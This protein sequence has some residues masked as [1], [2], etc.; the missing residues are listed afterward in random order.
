MALEKPHTNIES[1]IP[2][3]VQK[4][5]TDLQNEIES[6]KNTDTSTKAVFDILDGLAAQHP[7]DLEFKQNYEDIKAYIRYR[8]FEKAENAKIVLAQAQTRQA[9]LSSDYSSHTKTA[10]SGE[11]KTWGTYNIPMSDRTDMSRDVAGRPTANYGKTISGDSGGQS[12]DKDSVERGRQLLS[13]IP[14]GSM[15][16]VKQ[17]SETLQSPTWGVITVP[18]FENQLYRDM[19]EKHDYDPYVIGVLLQSQFDPKRLSVHVTSTTSIILYDRDGKPTG[20]IMPVNKDVWTELINE[21]KQFDHGYWGIPTNDRKHYVLLAKGSDLEN[22]VIHQKNVWNQQP[23]A[24]N[25]NADN[26]SESNEKDKKD[27]SV[28]EIE[29]TLKEINPETLDKAIGVSEKYINL[30]SDE[31]T[32]STLRGI[33]GA[34]ILNMLRGAGHN[35]IIKDGRVTIEPKPG[36]SVVELQTKLQTLVDTGRLS[37]DTLKIGLLYGSPIF[38]KYATELGVTKDA[39]GNV[40]AISPQANGKAFLEHV[41]E[42]RKKWN[43]PDISSLLASANMLESVNFPQA[44]KG[45]QDLGQLEPFYKKNPEILAAIAAGANTGGAST[46]N[47]PSAWWN[48]NNTTLSWK[49]VWEMNARDINWAPVSNFVSDWFKG[50]WKWFNDLVSLGKW[51]PIATLA[52]GGAL[53]YGI[54]RMFNVGGEFGFF[55]GIGMIFWLGV[56][57]NLGGKVSWDDVEKTAQSVKNTAWELYDAAKNKVTGTNDSTTTAPAES[58]D[59]PSAITEDQKYLRDEL[60]KNTSVIASVDRVSKN[61][62]KKKEPQTGKIDDYIKFIETDLKD[63]PLNK[64]F[65]EEHKESIFWDTHPTLF[66]P[67]SNL[68]AKI[69]KEVIRAYLGGPDMDQLFGTWNT[70]GVSEKENFLKTYGITADDIKNK[71]LSHILTQIHQKRS[72]GAQS[73]PT[74]PTSWS[75]QSSTSQPESPPANSTPTVTP[76]AAPANFVVD[77]KNI[78]SG[79]QLKMKLKAQVFDEQGNSSQLARLPKDGQGKAYLDQDR[80]VIVTGKLITAN[81][82]TLAEA[83]YAWQQIY[84]SPQHLKGMTS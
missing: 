35:L 76:S 53:I 56:L 78:V 52:I 57:N 6:S 16:T 11:E 84:I 48:T 28:K 75:N 61:A 21:P 2:L 8:S 64:L 70:R 42:L 41:A 65:P 32:K 68:N 25:I 80:V 3:D 83:T 49:I 72:A 59:K 79:D 50:F 19:I 46:P 54:W 45:F 10:S 60:L 23:N 33:H 30:V 71:N 81:G 47:T 31:Q 82:I 26:T 62:E 15:D 4:R 1:I 63:T 77:G 24:G 27:A 36:V 14:S 40:I 51:D 12:F 74:Q 7:A 5:L 18:K 55:K 58:T 9:Q 67:P 29:Q 17:N 66:S 13:R 44:I 39:Q 69:L 20:T 38:K 34:M 43:S 37:I 73:S 22:L